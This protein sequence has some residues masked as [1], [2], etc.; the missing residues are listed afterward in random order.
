MPVTATSFPC[1]RPKQLGDFL[2]S[3]ALGMAFGETWVECKRYLNLES[4]SGIRHL[5][6]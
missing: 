4:C 2:Q 5:F 1:I 6:L 3:R